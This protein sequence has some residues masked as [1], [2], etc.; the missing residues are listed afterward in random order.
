MAE[1]TEIITTEIHCPDCDGDD[2]IKHG[3][4]TGQQRYRCKTCKK[5]FRYNGKAEGRQISTEHIGA[6]IRMFYMG[7]SYKQIA[8]TMEKQHDIPEP[9]KQTVYAWVKEFTDQ[10]VVESL[11]RVIIP[12]TR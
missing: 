9:S 2:V 11:G 5:V 6:A 8:E 10:A 3:Q 1:Y 7:L 4:Q 12:P